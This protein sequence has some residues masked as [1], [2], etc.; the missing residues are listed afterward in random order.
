MRCGAVRCE[1]KAHNSRFL[2]SLND[3]GEKSLVLLPSIG[4]ESGT[5]RQIDRASVRE[6]TVIS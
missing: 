2:S 5:V 3:F 4:R 1:V 6:H